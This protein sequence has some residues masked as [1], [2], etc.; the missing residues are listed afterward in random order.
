MALP[1]KKARLRVMSSAAPV[2]FS[3]EATS[4]TDQVVYTID[5]RDKRYWDRNT[6]VVVEVNGNPPAVGYRIQHAGGKIHFKEALDPGDTVTVDGAYVTVTTAVEVREY[7]LSINSEIIDVTWLNPAL[8][9]FRERIAGIIDASGTLSGFY[10]VNNLL[11]DKILAQAPTVLELE[12]NDDL[13]EI[14]AFYVYLESHELQAAIE[15]AVGTSVGWQSDG[16][17]LVE[18]L[19]SP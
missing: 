13:D 10:N 1:G 3:S 7:T 18:Q 14:I 6:P 15:G 5:D 12:A 9:G 19:V 4:S 17:I 8:D 2:A 11:Q 16:D